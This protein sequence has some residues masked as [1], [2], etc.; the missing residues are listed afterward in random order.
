MEKKE[1]CTLQAEYND[2]FFNIPSCGFLPQ[3]PP[4]ARLP[5]EY[6]PVQSILD[7][8]HVQHDGGKGILAV[9]NA[10]EAEV[11]NLPNLVDITKN[12][13][14]PKRLAALFRAYAFLG[15][16]Y[17][18][19]SSYQEQIKSGD[20][21]PARRSLPA[22]VAQPFVC[23]AE[24]LD[25]FPWMDYHYSYSLGNYVKKDP[26]G[27]LHWK[28]LDMAVKFAGTTDEI[29]FIMLHV[30]INELGPELLRSVYLCNDAMND[31]SAAK[32]LQGLELNFDTIRGMNKRRQEMWAASNPKNYNDF[33]VFIMGI[34]GNEDLFGEGL[35]YEGCYDNKPQTFRGQTGAQDDIIPTEDIFIGLTAFYPENDLTRYLFD[36]RKYRPQCVQAFFRDL[37]DTMEDKALFRHLQQSGNVEG[38]VWLWRILDEVYRFRNGH[39]QFV[40]KYI[41]E[42]T[43]Y[44]KATGGTPITSWLINQIEACLQ[45]QTEIM[46]CLDEVT[47]VFTLKGVTSASTSAGPVYETEREDLVKAYDDLRNT[48]SDKKTLLAKQVKH[49]NE[50][51]DYDIVMLYSWNKDLGLNDDPSLDSKSA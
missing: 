26:A 18:L 40:Q 25:A 37:R 2:G 23:V 7:R 29:G 13:V 42:N 19:E 8:L 24:K 16:A 50:K 32:M 11:N 28:N 27:D 43:K 1:K 51:T 30:Y 35:V 49:L 45:Y 48:L 44:A 3:D 5:S 41:M 17:T 34:K 21:G 9:P 36:L 10:I 31:G 38:L 46:A 20:Y 22:Q 4:L 33:R 12:E 15:S 47:S 39:W 6:E 14:E